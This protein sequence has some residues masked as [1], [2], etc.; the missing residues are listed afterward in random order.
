MNGLPVGSMDSPVGGFIEP[1]GNIFIGLGKGAVNVPSPEPLPDVVQGTFHLSLHPG[2]IG[3]AGFGLEPIMM[4]KMEKLQVKN[5]FPVLP[6]QD[7]IFHVV[8]ENF[9]RHPLKKVESMDMAVHKGF[10]GTAL[11]KLDI[12]DPG[13]PQEQEK[14]VKGGILPIQFLDLKI[15]PVHLGL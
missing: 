5:R 4:G 11:Y 6:T 15:A 14:G 13:I 10:Q 1:D 2:A 8:V 3:R 7:D 12:H 9:D